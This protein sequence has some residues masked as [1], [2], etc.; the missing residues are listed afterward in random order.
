[1]SAGLQ[2][3]HATPL[4]DRTNT[5]GRAQPSTRKIQ[6][7]R[8]NALADPRLEA[9]ALWV[10][11]SAA[12]SDR[13]NGAA[14][15]GRLKHSP[16]SDADSDLLS[17][18]LVEQPSDALHAQSRGQ[19]AEPESKDSLEDWDHDYRLSRVNNNK[20]ASIRDIAKTHQLGHL[21]MGTLERIVQDQFRITDKLILQKDRIDLLEFQKK[22]S[23]VNA[24]H[25][26]QLEELVENHSLGDEILQGLKSVTMQHRVHILYGDGMESGDDESG[27]DNAR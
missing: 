4:S 15:F 9:V 26:K 22:L 7:R 27:G 10:A 3:A 25:D 18:T 6:A 17:Q 2:E 16:G 13:D 23:E 20:L 19:H 12:K 21:A 11:T 14:H 24:T 8:P 5:P 1:M